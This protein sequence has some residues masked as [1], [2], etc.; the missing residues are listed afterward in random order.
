[1]SRALPSP[2]STKQFACPSKLGHGPAG[3]VVQEVLVNTSIEKC[4]TEPALEVGRSAR[5]ADGED[6]GVRSGL[7]RVLVHGHVVELVAE[8][9]ACDVVRAH[10]HRAR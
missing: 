4:A 5:V 7:Q 6:V 1:M 10:V 8:P 2:V 3:D 9:A